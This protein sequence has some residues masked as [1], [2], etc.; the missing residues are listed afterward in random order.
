MNTYKKWQTLSSQYLVNDR[1][2][3]LRADSCLTVDGH[4]KD[5]YY[6]L[7]QNDWLTCL[8]IDG[9]EAVMIRQYR[10]GVQEYV[11]EMI[12]GWVD[13]TDAS[14]EAAAR[15]ELAEEIGYSGGEVYQTGVSYANPAN[16]TNKIYAFLAVGGS[17]NLSQALEIGEDLHVERIP[18]NQLAATMLNPGKAEI[19]QSYGLANLL[20]ARHYIE[21]SDLAAL[22]VLKGRL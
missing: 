20:F 7:E 13:I 21:Q 16:Q 3:K 14:P 8:A 12:A 2:L 19:C 11:L 18:L 4:T 1:W 17:C 9:D 22:Q 6:V 15:R 10:H 5:P